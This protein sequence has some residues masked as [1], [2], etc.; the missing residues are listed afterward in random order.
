VNFILL[1]IMSAAIFFG[2]RPI[3][4]FLPSDGIGREAIAAVIGGVVITLVTNHLLEKQH[5]LEQKN[6][7]DD[8]IFKAR[9]AVYD[10]FIEKFFDM[11]KDKKITE[12]ELSDLRSMLHRIN[13]YGGKEAR[14][15]IKPLIETA[16]E[17]MERTWK[18]EDDDILDQ[19]MRLL[20]E[21]LEV[22]TNL[23]RKD[24]LNEDP[25]IALYRETKASGVGHALAAPFEKKDGA[26]RKKSGK[27]LTRPMF[28][29]KQYSKSDYVF[30]VFTEIY[31]GKKGQSVTLDELKQKF[32][33]EEVFEKAKMEPRHQSHFEWFRANPIWLEKSDAETRRDNSIE[34]NWRRYRIEMPIKLADAEIVI[35]RGQNLDAIEGLQKLLK[36]HHPN[37]LK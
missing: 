21:K 31:G 12:G 20:M 16:E 29:G 36:L 2:L 14:E 34:K 4:D 35:R 23:F 32:G 17:V 27:D 28:L 33:S 37:L 6:K 13:A 1:L 24:L 7:K 3:F 15:H 5:Q 8:E 22:V 30:H 26:L 11:L 25:A 10:A 19:D 9:I 18:N